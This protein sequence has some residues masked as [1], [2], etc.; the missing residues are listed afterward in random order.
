[1]KTTRIG[2]ILGMC[3]LLLTTSALATGKRSVDEINDGN[4]A[5]A[6]IH[7]E[8]NMLLPQDTYKNTIDYGNYRYISDPR[9]VR[10]AYIGPEGGEAAAAMEKQAARAV[11]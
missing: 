1:M 7:A 8:T 5:Y 6:V 10:I 11:R 9:G 4:A 3:F 2:V